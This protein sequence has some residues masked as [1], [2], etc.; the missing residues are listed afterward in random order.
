[1]SPSIPPYFQAQKEEQEKWDAGFRAGVQEV[2]DALQNKQT[3]ETWDGP[4]QEWLDDLVK[5]MK[6]T[7]F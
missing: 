5:K 2:L 7:Y 6:N 4:S 1:M 3:D